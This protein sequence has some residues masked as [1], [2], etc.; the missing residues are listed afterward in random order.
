[1]GPAEVAFDVGLLSYLGPETASQCLMEP[2]CE[3]KSHVA[4]CYVLQAVGCAT[5][6]KPAMEV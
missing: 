3:S 1:M 2:P 4:S 5:E 6:E